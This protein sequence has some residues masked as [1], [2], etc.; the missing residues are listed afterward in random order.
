MHELVKDW[1]RTKHVTLWADW[2]ITDERELDWAAEWFLLELQSFERH[3]MSQ[4]LFDV[5]KAAEAVIRRPLPP[6]H[7]LP[8]LP[9]PAV[10]LNPLKENK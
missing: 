5:A 6:P 2:D 9:P 4:P 1:L 10:A 3:F 8:L 7:G